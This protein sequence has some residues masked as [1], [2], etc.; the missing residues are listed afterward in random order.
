MNPIYRASRLLAFNPCIAQLG[1]RI[2]GHDNAT[3]PIIQRNLNGEDGPG[4]VTVI[5][6]ATVAALA[7]TLNIES[8]TCSMLDGMLPYL[9]RM[10][11]RNEFCLFASVRQTVTVCSTTA[12]YGPENPLAQASKKLDEA[13]W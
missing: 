11:Q 8:I 2:T 12:I 3:S 7:D 13:F 6:D 9:D 1:K 5:H 4:Y 10:E